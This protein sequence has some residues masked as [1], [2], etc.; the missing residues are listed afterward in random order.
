MNSISILPS[1][2]GS[3]IAAYAPS[4]KRA[5]PVEK[6]IIGPIMVMLEMSSGTPVGHGVACCDI[7]TALT[8]II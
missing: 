1:W 3:P 2:P 4:E 5:P 7:L 6:L 8:H